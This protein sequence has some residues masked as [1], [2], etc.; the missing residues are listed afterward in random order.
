MTERLVREQNIVL[1]KPNQTQIYE[2]FPQDKVEVFW[3][4]FGGTK[5]EGI[6]KNCGIWDKKFFAYQ[7]G[8]KFI[9]TVNFIMDE[10]RQKKEMYETAC[11]SKLLE[12]F[13]SIGRINESSSDSEDE[14][15]SHICSVISK[16]YY[17][18]ASN[19][20]YANMCHMSESYFLKRF[21]AYTGTSPQHYKTVCR[22]EN[23]EKLLANSNYKITEISHIVGFGNSM[24][25]SRV[26]HKIKGVSPTEFREQ[27]KKK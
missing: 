20:E 17:R 11:V 5:A 6:L 15:M 13:V 1:Y 23:A 24:Y 18:D 26:F 14:A 2:Y 3:I 7:N 12:L 8:E 22:V 9:D 4:H 10:F 27:A 19:E 16:N 25:F 21:K